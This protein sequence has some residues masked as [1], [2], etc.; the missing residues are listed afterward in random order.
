MS[1]D[2]YVPSGREMEDRYVGFSLDRMDFISDD[3]MRKWEEKLREEFRRGLARV[4]RDA[5]VEFRRAELALIPPDADDDAPIRTRQQALAWRIETH[6]L[7][8]HPE[9]ATP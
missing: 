3:D 2:E 8:N 7:G 5:L 9:E 4:R 1:A 6:L